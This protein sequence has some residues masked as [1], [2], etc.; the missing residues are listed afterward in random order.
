MGLHDTSSFVCTEETVN[1]RNV[2]WWH[3]LDVPG[4]NKTCFKHAIDTSHI[5]YLS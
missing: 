2:E 4:A 3:L 5:R 1:N